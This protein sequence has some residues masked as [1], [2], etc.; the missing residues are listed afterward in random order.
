[1]NRPAVVVLLLVVFFFTTCVN[2]EKSRV[3]IDP[4]SLYQDYLVWGDEESGNVTL[5]LQYRAGGPN[6]A[7]VLLKVPAKTEL[8]GEIIQPDSSRFN[9]PYYEV[10]R[11]VSEFTGTHNIVFTD[12]HGKKYTTTFDFPVMFLETAIPDMISRAD[13]LLQ[14]KGLKK[15]DKVRVMLTDTS[16]YGRGI[17][18]I[19]AVDSNRILI[20]KEDLGMLRNGPVQLEFSR[21][22]DQFSGEAMASG[23]R[24]YLTYGLKREFMLQD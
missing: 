16:L 11:P 5:K 12:D 21:E 24:F 15:G 13:L 23:G 6:E 22:Q 2:N 19:V 20:S 17:E 8:D 1:M 14:F 18:R 10:N 9:G 7:A 3:K 4:D